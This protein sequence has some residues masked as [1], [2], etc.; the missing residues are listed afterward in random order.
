MRQLVEA[1]ASMAA[2]YYQM[3]DALRTAGAGVEPPSN[4]QRRAYVAQLGQH[5][6]ELAGVAQAVDNPRPYVPPP[7]I[8]ASTEVKENEGVEV[9]APPPDLI[10]TPAR[11]ASAEP[12]PEAPPPAPPE[13][14][15]VEVP[16]STQDAP[17]PP[18]PMVD[19]SKV[20]Y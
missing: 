2:W 15:A 4:E 16:A 13:E 12:E 11:V 3:A 8:L 18:P 10:S 19:P 7:A 9:K 14:S 1:H 20:K 5:F 17:P 6:P